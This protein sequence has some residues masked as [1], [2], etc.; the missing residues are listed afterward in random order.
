M[1]SFPD[2]DLVQSHKFVGIPLLRNANVCDSIKFKDKYIS[3]RNTC[4]SI[5]SYQK[6]YKSSIQDF[7][8]PILK[9]AQNMLTREKIM[10]NNYKNR[11][12]VNY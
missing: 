7:E 6:I 5:L 9:L 3:V 4:A 10:I 11:T 1:D 12:F 2:W 8:L